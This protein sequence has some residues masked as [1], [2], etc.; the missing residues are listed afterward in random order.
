MVI[1]VTLVVFG[2]ASAACAFAGSPG[3]LIAARAALGIGS[4]FL[5]PL[6]MSLLNI[7]F[8]PEERQRAMTIWLMANSIGIPLGPVL[9]GWLL[10]H[11]RWA[12]A[13]LQLNNTLS[14]RR[15]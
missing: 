13:F 7:L 5:I 3:E 4:A 9:G 2:L 6:S 1:L 11:Y 10:D 14:V 8:A 15:D 12:E